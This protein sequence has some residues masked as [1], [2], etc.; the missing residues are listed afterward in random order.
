MEEYGKFGYCK[1][2]A[3]IFGYF[4]EETGAYNYR[5]IKEEYELNEYLE[6]IVQN[7]NVFYR[8]RT[9]KN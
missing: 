5:M 3:R 8:L 4:N 1:F 2:L 6:R 7:E 9:E